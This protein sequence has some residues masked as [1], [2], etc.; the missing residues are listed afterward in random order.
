MERGFGHG[1]QAIRVVQAQVGTVGLGRLN[2]RGEVPKF[3]KIASQ[4]A[5]HFCQN[6]GCF[7]SPLNQTHDSRKLFGS[8]FAKSA[9]SMASFYV[10]ALVHNSLLY[11]GEAVCTTTTLVS[12]LDETRR[13]INKRT[14][15]LSLSADAIR[16]GSAFL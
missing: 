16:L 1:T 15:K 4:P 5:S 14:L 9:M 13:S 2:T 11:F 6:G 3:A 12:V 8:R 7:F 10:Y